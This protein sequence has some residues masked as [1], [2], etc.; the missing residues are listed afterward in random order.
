MILTLALLV[1]VL[2]APAPE[3]V[4]VFTRGE[5]DY[6][7]FRIPAVVRT[8][9]GELLAFAEGRVDGAGD[10]GDID[11]V[12]KRSSDGGRTW[13][14]LSVVADHGDG[15]FGNPTP[16]VERST[17]DVVLLLVGQ[18]AGTHES[19]I[20]RGEGSRDPYVCRSTDGGRSWSEP[21]ALPECDRPEWGWYATGPCHGIQLEHG[22]H[23]G[24][25]VAPANH[26]GEDGAYS[27]HLLLSDDGG[28]TWRI[29]A[30]DAESLASASIHPNESTVAE[31]SDGSLFVSSRDQHGDSPATRARARSLDG[32]ESFVRPFEEDPSLRGP[33]CQGAVLAL[34]GDRL[35]FAGPSDPGARRRLQIRASTWGDE[36][37]SAGE[38]LYPE[39]SAYS[40]LVALDEGEAGCLFEADDYARIVF[41]TFDVARATRRLPVARPNI[42]LIVSDDQGWN[43][44]GY[45]NAVLRTPNLDRLAETG[46]RLDCHYVQPQCTPTR[47]ALMTGRYPSRFGMHCT[48]ASNAQAF[49]LGTPTLASVLRSAGYATGMS[50]KW[51]LGSDPA[52]GP[53]HYGFDSSHGSLT[54]AVGMYDHRYR[55]NSPYAETW[56]RDHEPLEEVGHVTDLCTA[57]AVRW[58]EARAEGE[59]PWFF[60]LPLHAVHTPLVE[61][62]PRWWR[63]N[64]HVE[65]F[66]RRLFAAALSHMDD[67]VGRV[68]EALD[69]TGQRERTL[70]VFTSDNGAQVR[71]GGDAY[72]P[73]DP[74]LRDF[75]SNAPLRSEKTHVYEGGFRV[76]AFVSGAGVRS[77]TLC[78]QV[79]HAVDWLPTLA[80][81]AGAALPEVPLDGQNVWD[82]LDPDAAP[83]E[84]TIY[85]VWGGGRQREAL[86]H[87]DW[88]I[89]HDR[90]D[91]PWELYDLSG[92]PNEEEDLASTRPEMVEQLLAIYAA[93]RARDAAEASPDR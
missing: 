69:R 33:V 35:L 58:I 47:V 40:D 55:L 48:H 6:H 74:A 27:A 34:D 91:G 79:L 57:E 50:G 3:L 36:G 12:L 23:A 76:P 39:A 60:Y 52:W 5:S 68:V 22:E 41:A 24:R 54:G 28:H 9:D 73:P 89:L 85:T 78:T 13:G 62:D 67:G 7:T 11:V 18:P 4:D 49:P 59:E 19:A 21:R 70:I 75:S 38:V 87:G 66:D 42:L 86:R 53:N 29:G 56:H 83:V 8:L 82:R 37:W 31:L 71:H 63:L 2:T 25:L 46:T 14:P 88:K 10:A 64:E 32:G 81:V 65:P 84:R 93:E 61:G 17:G 1:P 72:P 44:V 80:H 20:R 77:G 16:I 90:R 92:D 45:H 30:V 43:D 51:H 26:S 15:T